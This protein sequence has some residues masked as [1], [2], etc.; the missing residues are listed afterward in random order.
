[1]RHLIYNSKAKKT[2]KKISKMSDVINLKQGEYDNVHHV[3]IFGGDGTINS[4]INNHDVKMITLHKYG[5][6]NDLYR[7][8]KNRVSTYTYNVND[9]KFINGFGYGIDSY[10]CSVA[11]ESSKKSYFSILIKAL[12]NFKKFDLEVDIDGV[13]YQFCNCH[14][15][16]VCNGKYF[17][18]GIMIAPKA[19]LEDEELDVVIV[20]DLHGLK[21]IPA[22]FLL[23]IKKHYLLKNNVFNIK[24]RNIKIYNNKSI[25]FQID[26]EVKTTSSDIVI[27][28]NNSI[29]IRKSKKTF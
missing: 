28:K 9:L 2:P 6:G 4:F 19:N 3:R 27:S 13:N 25:N 21:I 12:K 11:E 14:T 8:I 17:G 18:G 7:S 10:V 5:S 1:M 15:I 26:G 22:L 29:K 24:A 20:H 23:I 16:S